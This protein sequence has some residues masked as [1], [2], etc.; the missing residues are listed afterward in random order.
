M[1]SNFNRTICYYDRELIIHDQMCEN[2]VAGSYKPV[3]I[4][5]GSNLQQ[6][7][8]S[9]YKATKINLEECDIDIICNWPTNYR[10]KAIKL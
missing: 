2:Y 4:H 1:T 8:E 5:K 3:K 9:V 10:S 6:L 7:K